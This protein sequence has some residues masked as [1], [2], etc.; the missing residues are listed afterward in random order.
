MAR[1][2]E[3]TERQRNASKNLLALREALGMSRRSFAAVVGMDQE[4]VRKRELGQ[5]VWRDHQVSAIHHHFSGWLRE[6][7]LAVTLT[8]AHIFEPGP[9]GTDV[10]AKVLGPSRAYLPA[11][12]APPPSSPQAAAGLT[13]PGR[14]T[15]KRRLRTG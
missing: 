6:V 14:A 15:N 8:L 4:K 12:V 5:A 10:G 2:S 13:Q 1:T 3:I 11:T 9:E 7:R